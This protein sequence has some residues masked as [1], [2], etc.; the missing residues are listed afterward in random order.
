MDTPTPPAERTATETPSA[1][2]PWWRRDPERLA[3]WGL[4][5]AGIALR[6][7]YLRDFSGSPLF[8]LPIGADVGEYYQ[9]AQELANGCFFPKSPDI[10]A[11]VYSVFLA[12]VLKLGGGVPS[13]RAIQLILNFGAWLAFYLL[14]RRKRIPV[15][16][17][18]WFLAFVMLLPT[19]VYYQAELVSESLLVPLAAAFFWLRH[20]AGVAGTPSR[21]GWAAFGAGLALGVMNLTHPM[22]LFFSA[23]EV[24]WELCTRNCRRAA[25]LLA[26]L[27]VTVGSFCAAQ[28]I[29][30]RKPCGIQA[31][32][33]F[34][35]YLGNN[36]AA[37][38]GC[39]LR[40]G[41]HWRKV[42]REAAQ[43]AKRRGISAD[44]VFL[45]RA[46]DF[47]RRHPG[48]ALLLCGRKAL[49]VVS[50]REMPSGADLPPLLYFSEPVFY[51]LI[52]TPVLLFVAAFGLWRVL[53]G[54]EYRYI[55]YL[56][57]FFSMYLA[58]I[59]TVTSGRYRLVML[60]PAA[61]FAGVGMRDFKWRRYW[62]LPLLAAVACTAF[63]VTDYGRMRAEAAIL[64]SEAAFK[65]GDWRQSEALAAYALRAFEDP[66][67]AHCWELRGGSAENLADKALE[68][69][70]A[71]IARN[72]PD[73]VENFRR[74]AQRQID[75]AGVC[76]L[77]MT[78]AEPTFHRGWMHLAALAE[79]TGDADPSGGWYDR[80]ELWYGKALR[81]EPEA[82]D[83]CY[84]Y[85]RFRFRTGR[86]CG[87]AVA[88]ALRACPNWSQAWHLAGIVA[89][90][91]GEF[92]RALDCF[93]RA[94]EL[95]PDAATREVN[96]N[97]LRNAEDRLKKAK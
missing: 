41:K 4:A 3:V 91:D 84:N 65:R 33:G 42:H 48:K 5:L 18:L 78:K 59:V 57:L 64:Y 71:A 55:H 54:K 67:P 15:A 90:R 40:P 11:P 1:V 60:I 63:I 95:A 31:N 86:P 68:E 10:H 43:E 70:S 16:V 61:L 50:P 9:R 38:G 45:G 46:G 34:N 36:P 35:F 25:A 51:G 74:E 17:R 75:F 7:W 83:L 87:D 76:Y 27:A 56:L 77:K 23:A 12:L 96:L 52:L 39:Y 49:L 92:R 2:L 22:T 19:P 32:A 47:W 53:R 62:F 97:N 13:A 88:A 30:Y 66:D 44:A 21:R 72:R 82:P 81:C 26:A 80:A 37:N 14:L 58:Q 24:G 28:S 79:K 94:A 20:F 6:F 29:R 73:L 8:D 85:A 93:Y 89:M 69:R